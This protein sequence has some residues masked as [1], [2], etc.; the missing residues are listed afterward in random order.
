MG[1]VVNLLDEKVCRVCVRIILSH[2][3]Y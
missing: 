1:I 3:A 2:H